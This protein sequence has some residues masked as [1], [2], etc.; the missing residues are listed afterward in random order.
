MTI[1]VTAKLRFLSI[2]LCVFSLLMQGPI[3]G[4]ADAVQDTPSKTEQEE[5]NSAEIA[6]QNMLN[7]FLAKSDD[8]NEADLKEFLTILFRENQQ[9]FIRAREKY[10]QLLPSDYR[11]V[12]LETEKLY[13]DI[14]GS[15][16]ITA[17]IGAHCE[18]ALQYIIRHPGLPSLEGE[19][20]KKLL[21]LLAACHQ[22]LMNGSFMMLLQGAD[23]AI[24]KPGGPEQMANLT[25]QAQQMLQGMMMPTLYL[26]RDDLKTML[27]M[28]IVLEEQLCTQE[29]PDLAFCNEL[30]TFRTFLQATYEK[31][32][33]R[34][35][36]LMLDLVNEEFDAMHGKIKGMVT[37]LDQKSLECDGSGDVELRNAC[38]FFLKIFKR[39]AH[40]LAAFERIKN[41]ANLKV[42]NERYA[43]FKMITYGY[44]IGHGF[45]DLWAKDLYAKYDKEVTGFSYP[46]LGDWVFTSALSGWMF[47]NHRT[48]LMNTQLFTRLM[49][50]QPVLKPLDSSML[51]QLNV[52]AAVQV[53][54][55]LLNPKIYVHRPGKLMQVFERVG[56]AWLYYYIFERG[57]S[58]DKIWPNENKHMRDAFIFAI[59]QGKRYLSQ[60]AE[61]VVCGMV[62]QKNWETAYNYS[63][64]IIKPEIAELVVESLIDVALLNVLPK[65]RYLL[66]ESLNHARS[67][68]FTGR[69][70]IE[71]NYKDAFDDYK[72]KNTKSDIA[73]IRTWMKIQNY[74]ESSHL[75][76]LDELRVMDDRTLFEALKKDENAF[77]VNG[78]KY[79]ETFKHMSEQE[80]FSEVWLDS[81][82]RISPNDIFQSSFGRSFQWH[83]DRYYADADPEVD[84]VHKLYFQQKLATYTAKSVGGFLGKK[85]F[86]RYGETI[87]SVLS[88]GADVIAEVLEAFWLIS[89]KTLDS[90]YDYK[91]ELSEE[92][93]LTLNEIKEMLLMCFDIHS[94]IREAIITQLRLINV[95]DD[96]DI[97]PREQNRKI[98][99]Y[100]LNFLINPVPLPLLRNENCA[101]LTIREY[102]KI[103]RDFDRNPDDIAL[104]INNI[105]DHIRAN[106][107]GM[108]GEWIGE[109][110][111]DMVATN[112]FW[113]KGSGTTAN[114][115]PWHGRLAE[116]VRA[117]VC[118]VLDSFKFWK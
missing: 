52:M 28:L 42:T 1:Y 22:S 13:E 101:I 71:K 23:D 66:A 17:V 112:Y 91:T 33:N 70:S 41:S 2:F 39:S 24:L 3:F 90:Y 47:F 106:L 5:E 10:L 88:T 78:N 110:V 59:N 117:S 99:C 8:Q 81:I 95:L 65:N 4:V 19:A 67:S 18:N 84:N 75:K 89:P 40:A 15:M 37:F 25:A 58:G 80:A 51:I 11:D 74:Y 62:K 55:V 93:E 92:L 7:A 43:V 30:K 85:I 29:T 114:P 57:L 115:G 108:C 54:P 87:G 98:I 73:D 26:S 72:K 12:L 107:V 20:K 63:M 64:G 82:G 6:L 36:E 97:D 48:D 16:N 9:K 102:F 118:D 44:Y 100:G 103:V 77:I 96:D 21:N 79:F 27:D 49:G 83:L 94:P 53:L 109:G 111:A 113:S 45:Y 105:I 86:H 104:T 76:Q 61:L 34:L 116:A 56:T 50:A 31:N 60:R 38:E 46:N 14:I 69:K 32:S 35:S 68:I